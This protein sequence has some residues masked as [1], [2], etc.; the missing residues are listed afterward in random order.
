L[1]SRL[2]HEASAGRSPKEAARLIRFCD[3]VGKYAVIQTVDEAIKAER[4]C[5]S[6]RDLPAYLQDQVTVTA[7]EA[8]CSEELRLLTTRLPTASDV[9]CV[10]SPSVADF[11][12]S[13]E[14]ELCAD[15][16]VQATE[17][18]R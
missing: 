15:S 4:V 11:A 2:I 13:A 3:A 6:W 5:A 10:P 8:C 14:A 16:C 18:N 9:P 1:L 7:V 12:L 17:A